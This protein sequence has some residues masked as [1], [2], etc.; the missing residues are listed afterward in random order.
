MS[1]TSPRT[2]VTN[3][4]VTASFMNTDIRDNMLETA[5]AK[6]TTAGD[7]VYATAANAITPL[8]IGTAGY[9]L[10]SGG[11][12]P[13]W[14]GGIKVLDH[15]TSDTAY[16][17]SDTTTDSLPIYT[18]ALPANTL[19]ATGSL[20]ITGYTSYQNSSVTGMSGDVYLTIGS[21]DTS[22]GVLMT[23]GENVSN[24]NGIEYYFTGA[25]SARGTSAVRIS[26]M[27]IGRTALIDANVA[28]A[29]FAVD[30]TAEQ[31]IR[32]IRES[33]SVSGGTITIR[34]VLLTHIPD[35]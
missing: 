35:F 33:Q 22:D 13:V 16:A 21:S 5:P 3:E 19:G 32:I 9:S 1:F 29:A 4:L 23:L 11:S 26:G 2:W 30:L 27:G 18:F 12:A 34:E 15:D 31:T 7:I 24:G 20:Q 6:V 28:S 8:A 10:F 17:T 25:I 14:G